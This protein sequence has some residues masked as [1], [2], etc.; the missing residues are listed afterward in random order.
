MLDQKCGWHRSVGP[1][2][3]HDIQVCSCNV[4]SF[5]FHP[6]CDWL[7]FGIIS[8][9]L[10]HLLDKF[11]VKSTWNGSVKNYFNAMLSITASDF[12]LRLKE[13]TL[14][15]DAYFQPAFTIYRQ[16]CLVMCLS[17]IAFSYTQS[18]AS[19][20]FFFIEAEECEV[21][22]WSLVVGSDVTWTCFVCRELL[23]MKDCFWY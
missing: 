12:F 3:Y 2:Y 15:E 13:C 14:P 5:C 4:L 8:C 9:F 18:F 23:M 1:I 21:E 19:L 22:S 16:P 6:G 10:I 17:E 7:R 11:C 20:D